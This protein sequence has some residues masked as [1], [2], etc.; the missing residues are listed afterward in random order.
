MDGVQVLDGDILQKVLQGV[1]GSGED[2][3]P[4]V[5]R[6]DGIVYLLE[7]DGGGGAGSKLLGRVVYGKGKGHGELDDLVE[8]DGGR[9]EV[10]V[11]AGRGHDA[12][13]V[14]DLHGVSKPDEGVG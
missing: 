4:A 13:V 6:E 8:E 11:M 12:R 2:E 5:A 10:A 3:L 7:E 14:H 1:E 9:G